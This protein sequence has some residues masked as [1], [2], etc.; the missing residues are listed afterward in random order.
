M[1]KIYCKGYLTM[2]IQGKQMLT[3]KKEMN[4]NSHE[5]RLAEEKIW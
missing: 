1:Q 3:V 2:Q 5:S 4:T